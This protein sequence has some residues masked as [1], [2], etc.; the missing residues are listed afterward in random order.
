MLN[1]RWFYIWK[2]WKKL[3]KWQKTSN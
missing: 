1:S 2:N 3:F